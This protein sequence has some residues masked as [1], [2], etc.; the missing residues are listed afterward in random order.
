ME[1]RGVDR[2]RQRILHVLA[3]VH[4]GVL[5]A[6]GMLLWLTLSAPLRQQPW[7]AFPNLMASGFFGPAIFRLGFGLASWSGMALL[8]LM[9]GALGAAFA[10]LVPASVSQFRFTLLAV[11]AGLA[12]YYATAS[13]AVN[14]W[15]PL[16]PLYTPKP[17][18]YG[19]HLIYGCSL[20]MERRHYRRI[21]SRFTGTP[22]PAL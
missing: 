17:L 6:V 11:A 4:A 5:G 10:L 22:P 8:L 13:P 7:W 18:L 3:G 2:S 16:V 20:A 1:P 9:A 12:W 19:A 21:L 14:H 15:A